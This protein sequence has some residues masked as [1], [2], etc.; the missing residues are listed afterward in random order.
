MGNS[1]WDAGDWVN[2]SS[3]RASMGAS[4]IYAKAATPEVQAKN[5]TVRESRDSDANPNSTPV[6]LWLDGTG[7]MGE[8]ARQIAANE[9]GK[10]FQE[11]LDR[12]PV[13][14]PHLLAGV[15]GD[16]RYDRSPVQATQ[17]EAD[18]KV[19]DQIASLYLENG[20]G[21]NSSESYDA[22]WYFAAKKTVTDAWEKRGK[23]GFLFTIGDE[24]APYG[25][26]SQHILQF[27]GDHTQTDL[28]AEQLLRMAEEKY[29]VFHLMIAQGSH[30]NVHKRGD[31][32][33][34][35]WTELLGQ[36]AI[37]VSDY[38]K[39]GEIIVSTIQII[40]GHDV[41]KV[42]AS[43]SGDTSLVVADAVRALAVSGGG[44]AATGTTAL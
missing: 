21:G 6:M 28:T 10:V 1:R 24:E 37:W 18:I 43:W 13:S 38:T 4:E 20:G 5:I 17:F 9:L 11:I 15:I 22:A 23:K 34:S 31:A 40:A 8:V 33:K 42:I 14:D 19:S 32:V 3:L 27:F 25:L 30:V 44:A 16:V 29:E 7:S 12:K 36:R 26:T 35:S 2:T 41:D 39:L